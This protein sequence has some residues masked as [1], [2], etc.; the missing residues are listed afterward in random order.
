MKFRVMSNDVGPHQYSGLAD[1]EAKSVSEAKYKAGVE[2]ADLPIDPRRRDKTLRLLVL[3]H[4]KF[5]LHSGTTAKIK[6]E[7]GCYVLE[8]HGRNA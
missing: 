4:D 3:P 8:F 6:P 2:Y 7:A 1:I 5:H